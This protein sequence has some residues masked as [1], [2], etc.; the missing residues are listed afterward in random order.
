ML[1]AAG[2]DAV[3]QSKAFRN[4]FAAMPVRG[5]RPAPGPRRTP[6]A[7]QP[8]PA[9]A[10]APPVRPRPSDLISSTPSTR[11]SL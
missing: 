9:P 4:F 6:P 1:I 10:P 5:V 3:Q 7:I 8:P 2:R 11:P